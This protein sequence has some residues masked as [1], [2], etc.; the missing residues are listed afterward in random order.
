MEDFK[1]NGRFK[2]IAAPLLFLMV[3]L[4]TTTSNVAFGQTA[5]VAPSSANSIKNPYK[6]N[7]NATAAGK[8]LYK[9]FCAIC[10]GDK[11]KGD[12]LAG[13]NLKPRPG[14]FTKDAVQSQTDGAIYWKMTEGRAPMASY[15]TALTEQQRWQLVNYIRQLGGK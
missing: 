11:G 8:T 5:W 15:K 9:Q 13:M 12:G 1:K 7:A 10:H 2:F 3:L 4:F 14:N 6:G